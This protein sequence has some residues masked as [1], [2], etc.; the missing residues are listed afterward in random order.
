MCY[1]R[2]HALKNL[3]KNIFFDADVMVK[4]QIKCGLVLS[5]KC[6]YRHRYA[7]SQWSKFVVAAPRD[8]ATFW[9]LWWRI[10]LSIRVQTAQNQIWVV[11]FKITAEILGRIG[12]FIHHGVTHH[13]LHPPQNDPPYDAPE[14]PHPAPKELDTTIFCYTVLIT[15]QRE[16][17]IMRC[18]ICQY[19]IRH[20]IRR[21]L[22]KFRN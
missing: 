4:Q 22:Y 5:V 11:N 15:W 9:P 10:S 7:S 20:M 21:S 18:Q 6:S 2:G 16:N 17:H 13:T 3:R 1:A 8:S 12:T 19:F 14:P